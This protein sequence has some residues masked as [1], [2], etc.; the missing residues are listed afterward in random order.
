MSLVFKEYICP[1]NHI[2][3]ENPSDEEILRYTHAL[4]EVIEEI[5][6]SELSDE[7]KGIIR[8][9]AMELAEKGYVFVTALV[10]RESK[11]ISRVWKIITRRGLFAVRDRHKVLLYI[12]AVEEVYKNGMLRL[13]ASWIES[14]RE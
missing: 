10:D 14:V 5:E 8:S 1:F 9:K 2:N 3:S 12:I 13:N 4:E 7:E 11:G 6:E